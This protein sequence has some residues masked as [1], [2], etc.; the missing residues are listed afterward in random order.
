MFS[1]NF[2]F[3]QFTKQ[4]KSALC[5]SVKSFVKKNFDKP[6]L[7][8][9]FIDNEKY[10]IVIN[11][12]RLSFIGEYLEDDSFL[13]DLKAYFNE[14]IRYYNYQKELE[15]I[16]Q[17]Q[18]QI[19]KEQRKKAQEFKMSKEPPTKK[20]ISFYKSL[21]KKYDIEQKDIQELSKLDLRNLIREIKDE[22]QTD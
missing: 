15:P 17:V 5:H 22:H 2:L 8:E 11:S 19:A 7:L 3:N 21:C 9:N 13:K 20:Q 10:Y 1:K 6:D 16:K 18:K 12:S 14:C 4:Q